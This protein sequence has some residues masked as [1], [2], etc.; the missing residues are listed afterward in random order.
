M[1]SAEEQAAVTDAI[2]RV[3]QR[4]ADQLGPHR[5]TTHVID[6]VAQLHQSVDKLARQ[7]HESGRAVDCKAGCT[8]CCRARVEVTEPE[9]FHIARALK[10][11]S[12]EALEARVSR[13][14]HH[15][16]AI[17][18]DA[19]VRPVCA[20]LDNQL[21]SIYAV[22]PAACRKA[23]S[24]SVSHCER[25]APEI[26][27]HLDLTLGAE[28]LMRGTANAYRQVGLAT[29]AQELCA[30]VLQALEDDTAETRWLEGET[31]FGP[32]ASN[33]RAAP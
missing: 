29:T 1:L 3:Q 14:R 18:P 15:Q 22:R 12:V 30:A 23:H 21:C 24:L 20:F 2:A 6:F 27:Q 9:I 4:A 16:S 25:G 33:R 13:L 26:P 32:G 28:V 8:H 31:V 17:A 10:A 5:Q 11:G 19:P 7:V